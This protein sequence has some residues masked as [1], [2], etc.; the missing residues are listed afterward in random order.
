MDTLNRM[1]HFCVV[2]VFR[3]QTRSTV[4]SCSVSQGI[5]Q[6][7][8]FCLQLQNANSVLITILAAGK[9]V[10]HIL[11]FHFCQYG[12]SN[13]NGPPRL[14]SRINWLLLNPTTISNVNQMQVI[15][16]QS[17]SP[18]ILHLFSLT[19]LHFFETFMF[20]CDFNFSF[21][22][23][24]V[25]FPFLK[26]SA[27]RSMFL[28]P[29]HDLYWDKAKIR[30]L[31]QDE[32][33]NKRGFLQCTVPLWRHSEWCGCKEAWTEF[34]IIGLWD[35]QSLSSNQV[36]MPIVMDSSLQLP[37]TRQHTHTNQNLHAQVLLDQ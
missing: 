22:P 24:Q 18:W 8:L 23:I 14:L 20:K 15:F 28:Q 31:C 13:Q 16:H 12:V 30:W 17:A 35:F 9:I 1:M 4:Y 26:Y 32:A 7:G 29:R 37:F 11:F 3:T 33:C 2:T 34:F 6:P 27:L 5:S 36:H 19:V 21:Y 10:F 25:C